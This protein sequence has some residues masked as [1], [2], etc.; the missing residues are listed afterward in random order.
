[1]ADSARSNSWLSDP[2]AGS[3]VPVCKLV[4]VKYPCMCPYVVL[5]VVPLVHEYAVPGRIT[6]YSPVEMYTLCSINFTFQY[7][8]VHFTCQNMFLLY[9][10]FMG[11]AG[12]TAHVRLESLCV[13][14]SLHP[15]H[16]RPLGLPQTPLF[17]PHL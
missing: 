5:N 13:S 11:L 1:M 4:I 16:Q 17:P 9:L 14:V 12:P 6:G 7:A 8:N 10:C 3:A 15:T 2:E